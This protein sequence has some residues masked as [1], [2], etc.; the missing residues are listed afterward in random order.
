VADQ[1]DDRVEA[2]D[3]ALEASDLAGVSIDGDHIAESPAGDS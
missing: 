3:L 1:A 2:A